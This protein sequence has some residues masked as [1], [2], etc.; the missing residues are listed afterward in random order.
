MSISWTARRLNES[1]LNIHGNQPWIFMGRTDAEADAPILWPPD[2]KSRKD[3]KKLWCWER[4]RAGGDKVTEA[5]MVGWH[6]WLNGH[7]VE[8]DLG[9]GWRTGRSGVLQSM[10]LQ[11]VR[12]NWKTEQQQSSSCVNWSFIFFSLLEMPSSLPIFLL[13]Y[14]PLFS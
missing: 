14:L 5:E 9:D 6:Y 8:Q 11:R 2:A 10:G 12:H 4:L 1:I 3:W 7:E 13:G